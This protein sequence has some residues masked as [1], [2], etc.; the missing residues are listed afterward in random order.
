MMGGV[1]AQQPVAGKAAAVAN[2]KQAPT[3]ARNPDH[4]L[5]WKISGNGLQQPSYLFGTMHLLCADN[6]TLGS[7]LTGIIQQSAQV[8]FEL[9]L[10]NMVE[11][12]GALQYIKMNGGKKLADLLTPDDYKKV[13]EYFTRTPGMIPFEMMETFKPYF[14]SSLIAEQQ[15]T[16]AKKEGMEEAIM[17]EAKRYHKEIKG[18]ETMAFQAGVFDSIPYAQQAQE[19]VKSI[20]STGSNNRQTDELMAMYKEQDLDKIEAMTMNEEG[21]AGFTNLLLY[22]R[23][24]DWVRKMNPIMSGNAV[25]FAVGAAHL[26][27]EKGVIALLRRN[28]YT[29][30]PVDN[31]DH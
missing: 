16:C 29:V 24:A 8:Y 1:V 5:L 17:H 9:D 21:I 30:T 20:D 27:G 19:L 13:K 31:T 23:N 2:S 12:M 7:H 18:L 26:P 25:L 14:I 4:T 6:I 28:G 22:N 11:M 10:D 3:G 15:M